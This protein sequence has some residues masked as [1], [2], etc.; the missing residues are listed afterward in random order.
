MASELVVAFGLFL[1]IEGVIYS[2]FPGAVKRMLEHVRTVP[3]QTL[4]AG[5]LFSVA[6]GVL[7]VWLT[8]R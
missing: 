3:I 6:L 2:L 8:R 7:T 1:V 5:G 4:R